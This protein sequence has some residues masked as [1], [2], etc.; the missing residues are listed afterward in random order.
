MFPS[1]FLNPLEIKTSLDFKLLE[2]DKIGETI[3]EEVNEKLEKIM[4]EYMKTYIDRRFHSLQVLEQNQGF[5]AG[6]RGVTV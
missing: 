1:L 6:I 4:N 5:E 3:K 2:E